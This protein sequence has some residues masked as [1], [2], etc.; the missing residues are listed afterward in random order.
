MT[1]AALSPA[2]RERAVAAR[3]AK[4]GGRDVLPARHTNTLPPAGRSVVFTWPSAGALTSYALREK[5][6]HVRFWDC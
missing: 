5:F 6:T 1:G 4:S 2:G 3:T